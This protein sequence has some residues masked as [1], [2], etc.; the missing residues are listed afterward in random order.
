M[1]NRSLKKVRRGII[2]QL[3]M[4][5]FVACILGYI[6]WEVFIDGIFERKMA[7]TVYDSDRALYYFFVSNKNII[8]TLFYAIL[9]I[10]VTYYFVTKVIKY[11]DLINNSFDNILK[12]DSEIIKL[13]NELSVIS[14]KM[15][16]VKY[17]YITSEQVAKE[18]EMKKNDLIVYMAHDLKTPLT[19]II[20]YLTL[21]NDEKDIS[22][23]LQKKYIDIALD[24]SNRLEDL[25][26]EFFEITR[27]NLQNINLQ[28]QDINL[29]YLLE[30][31][32]DECYPM[33]EERKLK[34]V[35]DTE[36]NVHINADSEKLAR[37]FD[38]LL[39]NAINYS[40]ENTN[41]IITLKVLENNVEVRFKNYTPKIPDYKIDKLFDKFYRL[42]DSRSTTTGGAGLGLAISKQI[43]EIHGG[44]ISVKSN[45]EFT[46]FTVIIPK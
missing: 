8:V 36:K 19:S 43:V 37:V 31:L 42:D 10:S 35:L 7:D 41:I 15:N 45:D 2:I 40:F 30:Q 17:E 21:L 24:K 29:S 46:E 16:K 32:A 26:N 5:I 12:K 25:I 39:K 13:P 11:L 14:E 33:L 4:M 3:S 44:K 6:F 34:C 20:G 27:Y 18:A 38:N 1:K 28:K 9:V 23:E 22:P